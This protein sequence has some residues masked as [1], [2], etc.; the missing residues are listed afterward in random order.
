LTNGLSG[1]PSDPDGLWL[2][3]QKQVALLS[4]PS[5][6]VRADRAGHGIQD[7]APN[8]TAE[9]FRQVITAVRASAPLPACAMTPLPRLNGTCIDP[10]GG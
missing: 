1:S 9:A 4:T 3:L 8:L 2:K 5:I 7:D 10:H 6:L